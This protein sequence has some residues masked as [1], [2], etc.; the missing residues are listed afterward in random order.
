[1]SKLTKNSLPLSLVIFISLRNLVL[2]LF[3]RFFCL[4]KG[5]NK[6]YS[7]VIE[8]KVWPVNSSDCQNQNSYLQLHYVCFLQV[9]QTH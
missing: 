2:L 5:K 3:Q 8:K 7:P 6:M 9:Y 4:P 1:M